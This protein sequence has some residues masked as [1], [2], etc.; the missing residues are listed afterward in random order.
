MLATVVMA[1]FLGFAQAAEASDACD[2][3]EALECTAQQAQVATAR[4]GLSPISEEQVQGAEIYRAFLDGGDRYP[5]VS[6]EWRPGR[7]PELVIYSVNNR[8]IR[9]DVSM[10][11]WAKV[12]SESRYA[13]RRLVGNGII[14]DCIF[15]SIAT[16][17]VARQNARL[18]S[19]DERSRSIS[20]LPTTMQSSESTCG[21]GLTSDYVDLLMDLACDELPECAAM[22]PREHSQIA[23]QNLAAVFMLTGDRVSAGRLYAQKEWAPSRHGRVEPIS[24]EVWSRWN[25]VQHGATMT[26]GDQTVTSVR[27]YD[28][29]SPDPISIFLSQQDVALGGF[30]I[31]AESVGGEGADRGWIEGRVT[32]SRQVEGVWTTMAAHY[33]QLWERQGGDWRL[34][35]WT[36]G[37]FEPASG[38][39]D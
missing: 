17:E 26:W 19:T 39:S 8:R 16:I 11:L 35:S 31:E 12:E 10:E 36:V 21:G 2:H 32:Y 23:A 33:R 20:L 22:G 13:G 38:N 37:A 29:P 14:A 5:A 28:D 3:F 15:S 30:Q 1:A 7:S 27:R 25:N 4:L 9:H 24:S 6:F 34:W 18:Y